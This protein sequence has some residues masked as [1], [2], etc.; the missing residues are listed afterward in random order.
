VFKTVVA[1]T[2]V[3]TLTIQCLA[4]SA[5]E[6]HVPGEPSRDRVAEFKPAMQTTTPTLGIVTVAPVP[7][8]KPGT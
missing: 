2:L 5:E 7:S 4:H 6:P 3:S 1:W 8:K